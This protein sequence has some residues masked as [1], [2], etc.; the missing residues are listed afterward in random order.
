MPEIYIG[1]SHM[2]KFDT[3]KK[4]AVQTQPTKVDWRNCSIWHVCKKFAMAK[5]FFW[6]GLGSLSWFQ[7]DLSTC[8]QYPFILLAAEMYIPPQKFVIN[9]GKKLNP[10]PALWKKTNDYYI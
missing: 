2:T 5:Q 6:D 7:S 10:E 3:V 8:G 9:G 1:M 4:L